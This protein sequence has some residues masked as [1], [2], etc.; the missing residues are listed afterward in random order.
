M[1]TV[2]V[3]VG[4]AGAVVTA[5]AVGGGADAGVGTTLEPILS[6]FPMVCLLLSI[7]SGGRSQR[8]RL[9]LLSKIGF[10]PTVDW[11]SSPSLPLL[12]ILCAQAKSLA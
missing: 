3:E 10:M 8:P 11:Y 12:S 5:E 6:G 1:R 9:D 7:A 2:G 4:A